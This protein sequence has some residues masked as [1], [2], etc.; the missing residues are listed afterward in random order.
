[1]NP[2][3]LYN[4][5]ARYLDSKV[6]DRFGFALCVIDSETQLVSMIHVGIHHEV[7]T[8]LCE[9]VAENA[10]ANSSTLIQPKNQMI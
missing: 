10:D 4:E 5:I 6:Q 7:A 1:M 3:E 8:R 2:Q 9:I